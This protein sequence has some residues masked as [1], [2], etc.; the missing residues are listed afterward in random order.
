MRPITIWLLLSLLVVSC[1]KVD[2]AGPNP[3]P[4]KPS[5]LSCTCRIR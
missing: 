2:N 4:G 1:S 5:S 3:L